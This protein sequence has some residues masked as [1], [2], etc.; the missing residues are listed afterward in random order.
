M[1]RKY[2]ESQK[3]AT[4]EY[5]K[6]L[7]SISIRLKK[8]DYEKYKKAAAK[9]NMSLREFVI[10]SMNEKIQNDEKEG[11]MIWKRKW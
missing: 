11:E 6:S 3:R 2:T 4:T 7:A 9:R 5:L 10:S 8:E 1:G